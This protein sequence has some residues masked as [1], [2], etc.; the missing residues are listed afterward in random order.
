MKI[1]PCMFT[2][3]LII[4]ILEMVSK[5]S[6]LHRRCRF[7]EPHD[8][9]ADNGCSCFYS[10][11]HSWAFV[12]IRN[13]KNLSSS[14]WIFSILT[15]LMLVDIFV[16]SCN[17]KAQIAFSWRDCAVLGFW[18]LG[19]LYNTLFLV[20][21]RV[22]FF[23]CALVYHLYLAPYVGLSLKNICIIWKCAMFYHVM[24]N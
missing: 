18:K 17:C 20:L 15:L 10:R 12:L 7:L 14:N 23:F 5:H 9:I 6:R 16:T 2:Y 8:Q 21:D 22:W 11:W 3:L 4:G 1:S 19:T 13:A 24:I